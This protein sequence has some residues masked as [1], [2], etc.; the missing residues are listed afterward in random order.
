MK[1]IIDA[2]SCPKKTKYTC[3]KIAEKYGL[4]L[5]M[6]IDDS[7]KL[8]GKFKVVQVATSRDAVDFEIA[9]LTHKED[10]VVTHDYGLASIVI[11]KSLAVIHPDGTLYT[12]HNLESL[13]FQRYIG[14]K[15]RRLGGKIKG[16]KKR[17]AEERVPFSEVLEGIIK[18]NII[19]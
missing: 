2:D 7:H 16:M 8:K 17:R 15:M 14:N 10:I 11:N 18:K 9:K 1:L 12:N 6:V 5:I 19:D 3:M 4:E 13:M